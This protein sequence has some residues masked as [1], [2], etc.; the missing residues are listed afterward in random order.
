MWHSS[1]GDRTLHG[2]EADLV[3]DAAASLASNIDASIREDNPY[4]ATLL[5]VA[6]FA[7][8]QPTQQLA[9]LAEVAE[10]LLVDD[11][12][13]P[14]L[15]A[16]REATVAVIYQ[17]Y[18]VLIETEILG[19]EEEDQDAAMYAYRER[20]ARLARRLRIPDVPP[21][22]STD[23][24]EWDFVLTCISDQVLWDHDWALDEII[25]D[26]SPESADAVRQ[27]LG[28]DDQYFTHIAPDPSPAQLRQIRQR[29]NQILGNR[30]LLD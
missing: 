4:F 20:A 26:R 10:A 17:E 1:S 21:A 5:D 16:L 9:M 27:E 13:P 29:L 18:F 12:P 14:E 30:L 6:L 19:E 24:E 2:D 8:L 11:V 23:R 7:R 15:T 3:R 25:A 28:M 22:Q